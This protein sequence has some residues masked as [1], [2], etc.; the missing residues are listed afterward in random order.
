MPVMLD[1]IRSKIATGL[2]R[3]M[4]LRTA[5]RFARQQRGAVAVEFGLV[6]LPFLG[7]T[8]AILET[9]LV[10][11]AGQTL[12]TAVQDSARLVMTGQAQSNGWSKDDFK[13]QVCARVA[14]LFDCVNGVYVDVR[15]YSSFAAV[16][17][18]PPPI[19]NGQF[20]TANL[21]FTPGSDGDIE[22]VTLY[23]EWPIYVSLLGNNLTNLNGNKR[24]LV[25]TA[26]F[27]NEPFTGVTSPT[28]ACH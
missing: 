2:K 11:F 14:G 7:L 10:F 3:L 16:N 24:L 6:A 22:V 26:V 17:S 21:N 8:F 9:A 1:P 4:P 27:C 15:T 5:R 25:A 12:E 18:A 28:A 13:N 23:Y 19:N 20:D